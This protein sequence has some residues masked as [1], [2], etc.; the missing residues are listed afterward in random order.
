LKLLSQHPVKRPQD[1]VDATQ[2]AQQAGPEEIARAR[3]AVRLISE[4]GYA[5]EKLLEVDLD[6]LLSRIR[7]SS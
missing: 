1:A 3:R 5:R 4:R 6:S 2:L 7:S